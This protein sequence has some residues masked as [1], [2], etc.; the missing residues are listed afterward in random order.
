[1]HSAM[2]MIGRKAGVY[3][4]HRKLFLF[5]LLPTICILLAST[6]SLSHQLC[7]NLA[8]LLPL[9]SIFSQQPSAHNTHPLANTQRG[10]IAMRW[11]EEGGHL[12][13]PAVLRLIQ[14]AMSI[15]ISSLRQNV[16]SLPSNPSSP[17]CL[18]HTTR[19]LRRAVA[20]GCEGRKERGSGGVN[21][22]LP[23]CQPFR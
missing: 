22:H 23:P 18:L 5:A 7:Q 3:R 13:M 2:E 20:D 21:R 19:K 17:H 16:P 11:T 14:M 10:K 6:V 8:T 9:P 12:E 4:H 1:M 15:S